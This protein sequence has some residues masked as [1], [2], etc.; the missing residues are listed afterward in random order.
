MK[1]TKRLFLSSCP[2]SE[3]F[4]DFPHY[5]LKEKGPNSEG[6]SAPGLVRTP[7]GQT[8]KL[9]L[10][11]S[12]SAHRGTGDSAIN[13]RSAG[14][15]VQPGGAPPTP[16]HPQFKVPRHSLNAGYSKYG[17]ELRS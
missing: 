2:G 17:S 8:L 11:T 14:P 9:S 10:T 13:I 4:S 6:R 12:Q 16:T 3:A 7:Q 15:S 1:N 5:H